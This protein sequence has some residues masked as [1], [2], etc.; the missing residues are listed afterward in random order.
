MKYTDAEWAELER[1]AQQTAD[2]AA[3]DMSEQEKARQQLADETAEFYNSI[4]QHKKPKT[5]RMRA[6]KRRRI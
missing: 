6:L 4:N 5:I 1:L 2:E 3:A